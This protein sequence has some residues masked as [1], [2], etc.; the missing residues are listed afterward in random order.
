M[1]RFAICAIF[2]AL[3]LA[4][5]PILAE[6]TAGTHVCVSVLA[7]AGGRSGT[8]ARDTLVKFL[9]KQKKPPLTPVPL[10]SSLPEEALAEAKQ[11]SCEYVVTTNLVEE[12]TESGY[13]PGLSGVSIPN[14]FVTTSY[15]L[16]KVSDGAEVSTG[17]CK[18]QD[19]GSSENAVG[20][21]MNKIAA[22]VDAAL[23]GAK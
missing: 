14:F 7:G 15:K 19:T 3:C 18:A 13:G 2:V 6:D 8:G 11:K 10:Q 12:H 17:S 9:A 4:S 22:K 5:I 21:T 20:F 16:N 1:F 23:K